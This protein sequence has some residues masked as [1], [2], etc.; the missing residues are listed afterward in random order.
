MTMAKFELGRVQRWHRLALG[1]GLL[2]ALV[3]A[4]WTDLS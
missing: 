1:F 2:A 3:L 4:T